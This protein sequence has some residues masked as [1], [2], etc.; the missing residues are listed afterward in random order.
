MEIRA[1]QDRVIVE[2]EFVEN[3]SSSG[4]YLGDGEAKNEGTVLKA[5]PGKDGEMSVKEGDRVIIDP[6]NGFK[7][8][9]AGKKLLVVR[10]TD[11]FAVVGE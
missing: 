4:I 11:I 1:I 2:V 9:V 6:S 10:E 3:V 7:I 5:G 8:Q